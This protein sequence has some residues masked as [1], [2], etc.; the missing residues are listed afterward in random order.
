MRTEGKE[1]WATEATDHFSGILIDG[2]QERAERSSR[3]EHQLSDHTF[4]VHI[5]AEEVKQSIL[6]LRPRK[7]CAADNVVGEMLHALNETNLA[8]LAE[9][10]TRRATGCTEAPSAWHKL[11]AILLPRMP[12]FATLNDTRAITLLP[13]LYKVYVR[14]LFG[15]IRTHVETQ[16]HPWTIGFRRSH[17]PAEFIG[18]LRQAIEYSIQWRK[19]LNVAKL[20][21]RKAFDRLQHHRIFE[22]FRAYKV[23]EGILP[24]EREDFTP[25]TSVS[26]FHGIF[27][28]GVDITRGVRQGDPSA[29]MLFATTLD[30]AFADLVTSWGS[31]GL[32]WEMFSDSLSRHLGEDE[33]LS[34]LCWAD[35]IYLL[36]SSRDDLATMMNDFVSHVTTW[37]LGVQ[38]DETC[39]CTT[40]T[41]TSTLAPTSTDT[42]NASTT[43]IP[44]DLNGIVHVHGHDLPT[45]GP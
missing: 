8:I 43:V 17:Q 33:L 29:P 14:C 27:S 35:D 13:V 18:T 10:F 38:V 3:V 1:T 28:A 26:Q 9:A 12:H 37:G 4:D 24:T 6:S 44:A 31:K 34:C 32:G 40:D 20:E 16:L 19:P 21:I 25:C 42:A 5:S 45:Y 41:L 22:S 23:D 30:F 39:W 7:S 15:R 36:A 2:S 11:V